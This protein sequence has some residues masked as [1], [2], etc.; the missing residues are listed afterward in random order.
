MIHQQRISDQMINTIVA[1]TPY[2]CNHCGFR[3]NG[4]D[5]LKFHMKDWTEIHKTL[6]ITKRTTSD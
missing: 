3:A 2:A 5:L 6:K 1:D 4:E